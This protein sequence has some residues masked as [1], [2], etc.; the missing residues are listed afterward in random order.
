M[1]T[2]NRELEGTILDIGGGGEGIIGRLYQEQVTAIDDRQEELDE[3]PG[4]FKKVL[5]DAAR[6]EYADG[7][8]DH[9]T[10]FYSLM[11]M[12]EETQREA[13]REAVRVMRRN[14]SLHIWDCE[15]NSAYPDPFLVQM[16]IRLPSESIRTAYGIVKRDAQSVSSIS[17]LCA[18]AGAMPVETREDSGH[19]YLCCR[20]EAKGSPELWN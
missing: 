20:R 14:G 5:M 16:E 15:I 1:L 13:I 3:A 4:G 12:S 10:F 11:Y 7:S 8:F 18:E 19:F 6:L 17:R 9:V 2:L